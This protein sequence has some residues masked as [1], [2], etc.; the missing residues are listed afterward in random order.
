MLNPHFLQFHN[1]QVFELPQVRCYLIPLLV[2]I[3]FV[4]FAA[5]L[6]NPSAN[7]ESFGSASNSFTIDFVNI[8]HVGNPPDTAASPPGVGSVPYA[9]RIAK[10]ETSERMISIAN[11]VGQL[12]ISQSSRGDHKPATQVTWNE[13]ARFVNWLN[14]SKGYPPAYKFSIQPGSPSY[15][16]NANAEPWL[17]S[18]G[19]YDPSNP[20]RNTGAIYFLPSE[21]EWFRAV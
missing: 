15:D 1:E 18:D 7:A 4:F 14:T 3:M 8:G 16:P 5:I 17:P 2:R 19:G 9:Y 10:F 20:W 6:G 21:S 11:S 13:A 12:G